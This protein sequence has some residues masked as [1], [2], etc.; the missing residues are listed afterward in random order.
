MNPVPL[1]AGPTVPGFYGTIAPTL[2]T[3]APTQLPVNSSRAVAWSTALLPLYVYTPNQMTI[4]QTQSQAIIDWSSFNIGANASVYFNQQGNTSWAALNRIWDA[5]P[6]QIYGHLTADGKIYLINQNGILFGPGSQVNVYGLVASSLN[7][8]IDNFLASTLAVHHQ[9]GSPGT[10]AANHPGNH[11]Y[12]DSGYILQH[13]VADP[14][15]GLQRRDHHD[16]Q[17]RL[18]LPHRPP[19]GEL[20]D[21]HG[22]ERP[23]RACGGHRPGAGPAAAA[24]GATP[25]A[26]PRRRDPHHPD[27]QDQ[28][29]ALRGYTAT[30]L[31]GW[32]LLAPIPASSA[33]TATS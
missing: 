10:L 29:T 4:Y 28:L 30:N 20:R 32:Y 31:G 27:G 12:A 22:A 17:L 6:S 16:G 14:R 1:L 23:D 33:C 8:S 21:H 7:L 15:R 25:I 26:V 11:Q 19:G 24:A 9:Q 3:V 18:G 5:N 2:R 13:P